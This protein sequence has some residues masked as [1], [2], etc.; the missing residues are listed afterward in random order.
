MTIQAQ[1]NDLRNQFRGIVSSIRSSGY[2]RK[3]ASEELAVQYWSAL[4]T[5][6][7]HART[8]LPQDQYQDFF[9][10]VSRQEASLLNDI[11]SASKGYEQ[12]SGIANSRPAPLE[13]EI[14][15]S[16]ALLARHKNELAE[17]RRVAS[18]ATQHVL[19]DEFAPC[20]AMP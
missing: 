11:R 17:F 19:R 16:T 10:W 15:W 7:L 13:T 5:L 8:I 14:A 6:L 9:E 12:L 4:K 20:A 18:L 1:L 2:R 3:E